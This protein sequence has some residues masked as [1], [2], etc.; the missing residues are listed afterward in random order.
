MTEGVGRILYFHWQTPIVN[1]TASEATN[2][3]LLIASPCILCTTLHYLTL[4]E[5]LSAFANQ[6]LMTAQAFDVASPKELHKAENNPRL[7]PSTSLN[8]PTRPNDLRTLSGISPHPFSTF[9]LFTAPLAFILPEV[10]PHGP[11][12]T[13]VSGPCGTTL[14]FSHGA[15][16]FARSCYLNLEVATGLC[17]N[18]EA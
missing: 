10:V 13:S 12:T 14:G 6:I 5:G 7:R 1:A 8:T 4:C 18:C 3:M 16:L 17:S 2:H 15:L 9:L 11:A